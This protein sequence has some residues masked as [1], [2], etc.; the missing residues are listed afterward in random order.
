MNIICKRY[1]AQAVK[2]GTFIALFTVLRN[3]LFS[4]VF[5]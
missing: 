5:V 2:H 1:E 4:I 3:F